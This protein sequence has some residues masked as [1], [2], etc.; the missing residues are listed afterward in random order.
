MLA[1]LPSRLTVIVKWSARR[2]RRTERPPAGGAPRRRR[3]QQ[4]NPSTHLRQ[5][6][7]QITVVRE[8]SAQGDIRSVAVSAEE[9]TNDGDW[10]VLRLLGLRL[11]LQS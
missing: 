11:R 1:P 6:A 8:Q 2:L 3:K 9:N 5:I 4:R 10:V 7:P